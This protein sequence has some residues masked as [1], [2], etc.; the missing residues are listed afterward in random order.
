[1]RGADRGV[2]GAARHAHMD[3]TVC[4][5]PRL[6]ATRPRPLRGGLGMAGRTACLG[7]DDRH[8]P[9]HCRWKKPNKAV[10]DNSSSPVYADLPQV[11][12]GTPRFQHS[13]WA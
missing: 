7:D 6:T 11:F 2:P 13:G 5:L 8:Q 3:A 9:P 10:G 4:A 1:M 12:T